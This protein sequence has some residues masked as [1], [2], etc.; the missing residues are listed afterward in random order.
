[1]TTSNCMSSQVG[2]NCPHIEQNW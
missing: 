1:M 2:W